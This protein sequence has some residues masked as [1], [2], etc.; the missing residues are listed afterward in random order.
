M[1]KNPV[2]DLQ[3]TLTNRTVGQR[4][5]KGCWCSRDRQFQWLGTIIIS[6]K[7]ASEK[8]KNLRDMMGVRGGETA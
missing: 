5:C 1:T 3:T 4:H 8:D 6:P 7:T 2:G